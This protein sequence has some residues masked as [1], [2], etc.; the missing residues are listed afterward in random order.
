MA[1]ARLVGTL[2]V[3]TFERMGIFWGTWMVGDDVVE[4]M[5]GMDTAARAPLIDSTSTSAV[6]IPNFR[7]HHSQMPIWSWFS[8]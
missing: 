3:M 8:R 6:L 2:K 1:A 4:A 7:K 5:G